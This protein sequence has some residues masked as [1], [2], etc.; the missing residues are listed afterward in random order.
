[1]AVYKKC[2]NDEHIVNSL[3]NILQ[4]LDTLDSNILDQVTTG[5]GGISLSDNFPKFA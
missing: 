1:M 3:P 4:Y 5:L 2:D